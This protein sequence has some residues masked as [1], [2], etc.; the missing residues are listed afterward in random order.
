DIVAGAFAGA[1]GALGPV[2]A[3][4]IAARARSAAVD[5]QAEVAAL[6][7]DSGAADPVSQ[8][9][10]AVTA[11]NVGYVWQITDP[12][13]ASNPTATFAGTID[14]ADTDWFTLNNPDFA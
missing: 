10:V 14:L 8:V 2:V 12:G 5:E 4:E 11:G 3:G 1:A 6:F 9:F 13:G 7:T